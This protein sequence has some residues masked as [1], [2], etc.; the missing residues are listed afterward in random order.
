MQPEFS[1][2]RLPSTH[3]SEI[4]SA[5]RTRQRKGRE[6]L[7]RL[8]TRYQA[9][10]LAHISFKFRAPQDAAQDLLQSFVAE[11]ILENELLARANP[12]R[13]RFRTF[14]LNALDRVVISQ[15]RKERAQKR[16]PEGGFVPREH[17]QTQDTAQQLD[18]PRRGLEAIGL[19][20]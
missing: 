3:W 10:L 15:Q 12:G 5:S 18:R 1:S 6:A 2:R 4:A 13:G 17:L 8:L 16:A 7:D 11:K 9:A 20:A 14:L 19:N